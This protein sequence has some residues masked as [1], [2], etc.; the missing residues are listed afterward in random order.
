LVEEWSWLNEAAPRQQ[1]TEAMTEAPRRSLLVPGIVLAGLTV[2]TFAASFGAFLMGRIE[3]ARVPSPAGAFAAVTSFR[4]FE[5]L[6][7]RSP[8]SGG[9][10]AGALEVLRADGTSCRWAASCDGNSPRRH[11]R[12]RSSE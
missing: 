4:R 3:D 6:M 7:P 9:D 8:G 2:A 12:R 10:K 5:G 11:A 1:E